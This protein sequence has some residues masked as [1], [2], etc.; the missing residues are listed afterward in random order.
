M[1]DNSLQPTAETG[2]RELLL[3]GWTVID[4][5]RRGARHKI[6]IMGGTVSDRPGEE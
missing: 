6:I 1:Q 5:G 4:R 3:R 2:D